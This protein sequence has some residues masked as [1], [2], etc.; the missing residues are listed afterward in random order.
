[1]DP[2]SPHSPGQRPERARLVQPEVALPVPPA[3]GDLDAA[4]RIVNRRAG[5]FL[6]PDGWGRFHQVED[7]SEAGR[8]KRL[9]ENQEQHATMQRKV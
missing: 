5:M 7:S 1:M 3:A 4:A 8:A 9:R 2:T 6:I